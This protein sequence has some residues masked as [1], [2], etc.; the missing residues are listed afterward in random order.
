MRSIIFAI[1]TIATTLVSAQQ[2]IVSIT[3]PLTGT[4]YTAGKPAIISWIQPTVDT[5]PAI[6]IAQGNPNAL[7]IVQTIA[8]NV[9]ATAG[10]YTWNIPADFA[11]GSDYALELG[12]SPNI[13]FTG[14]FT[15]Q[16]GDGTASASAS[17][18][19]SSVSSASVSSATVSSSSASVVASSSSSVPTP[20]SSSSQAPTP[21]VSPSASASSSPSPAGNAA[22]KKSTSVLA[23]VMVGSV[24]VAMLLA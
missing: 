7:Q 2:N 18:S 20:S 13:S 17:G 19:A 3:S 4:V 21:S 12:V 5:I 11:P 14:L 16:A 22:N 6:V 10:S 15:I 1:A 23:G 8:N 24:A 9:D